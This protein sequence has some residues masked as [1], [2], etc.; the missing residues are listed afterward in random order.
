MDLVS[1]LSSVLLCAIDWFSLEGGLYSSGQFVYSPEM[2]EAV[3]TSEQS[4]LPQ[5]EYKIRCENIEAK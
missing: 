4:A 1:L 2:A 3:A 5:F